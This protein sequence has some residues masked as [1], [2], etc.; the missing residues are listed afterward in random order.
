M[1][2]APRAQPDDG[3]FD[4]VSIERGGLG[5]TVGLLRHMYGDT[6]LEQRGIWHTR[7][8][9]V[10]AESLDTEPVLLDVDGEAPGRLPA[11]FEVRPGALRLR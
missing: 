5:G 8:R 4:V 2:V 1:H 11:T 9:K 3:L 6:L 10:V 7:G